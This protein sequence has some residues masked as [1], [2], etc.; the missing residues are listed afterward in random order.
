M[1]MAEV[2]IVVGDGDVEVVTVGPVRRSKCLSML[3][4]ASGWAINKCG[5]EAVTALAT[6]LLVTASPSLLPLMT[7]PLSVTES[8]W[9]SAML[10]TVVDD[11][12]CMGTV[13]TAVLGNADRPRYFC[14]MLSDTC[15]GTDAGTVVEGL[16]VKTGWGVKVAPVTGTI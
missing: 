10:S 7:R 4:P 1:F 12:A 11:N 9:T 8:V 3:V 5:V 14:R 6:I 2:G 13:E 16:E 15:A